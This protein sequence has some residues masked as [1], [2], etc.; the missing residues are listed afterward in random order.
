MVK[1]DA[2]NFCMSCIPVCPTG[3]IDEWRVVETTYSLADQYGFAELPAQQAFSESSPE[4]ETSLEALDDGIAALLAEAH[5][6]AGGK[7]R[8]PASA[9]RSLR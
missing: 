5:A 7:A 8:A 1:A 4:D 3:S 6:G 9:V 2:C